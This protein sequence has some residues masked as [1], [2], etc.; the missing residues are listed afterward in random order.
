MSRPRPLWFQRVDGSRMED[1]TKQDNVSHKAETSWFVLAKQDP[2]GETRTSGSTRKPFRSHDPTDGIR[3]KLEIGI[4]K[5][6]L[7]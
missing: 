2:E 6:N 1:G 4:S 3:G 5:V 7:H